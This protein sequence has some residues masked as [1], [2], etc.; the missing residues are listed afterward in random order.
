MANWIINEVH[1]EGDEKLI[2]DLLEK[3]KV[4]TRGRGTIDFNK[5]ISKPQGILNHTQ[6]REWERKNW[7]ASGNA[8]VESAILGDF[9]NLLAFETRW[10]P[11]PRVITQL[12]FMYPSL[13]FEYL[14]ADEVLGSNIGHYHFKG[15]GVYNLLVK[16]GIDEHGF[17]GFEFASKLWGYDMEAIEEMKEEMGF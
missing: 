17:S 7:G 5:V 1:I 10:S 14:Y 13:E 11:V 9:T 12:A 6:N 16:N 15:H 8:D 4:D 3:V 2:I